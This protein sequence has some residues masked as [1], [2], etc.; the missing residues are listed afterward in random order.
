[1]SAH[2][3][4]AAVCRAY[5]AKCLSRYVPEQAF[6]LTERHAKRLLFIFSN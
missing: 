1:M 4:P 6:S 3:D 2:A 5:Y